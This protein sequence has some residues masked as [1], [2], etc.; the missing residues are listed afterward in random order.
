VQPRRLSDKAVARI[1]KRRA[2]A[3]GLDPDR[4]AGHSLR[5]GVASSAAAGGASERAI[6]NQTGHRSTEM[7]RRYIREANLFAADNAASLAGLYT[8]R[9]QILAAGGE[10]SVHYAP[11]DLNPMDSFAN[12]FAGV[13]GGPWTGGYQQRMSNKSH[14]AGDDHSI[15][16]DGV[17]S[18]PPRSPEFIPR[19]AARAE[20][21][22]ALMTSHGRVVLHGLGGSGKTWLAIDIAHDLRLGREID[23]IVWATARDHPL[24][25]EGL[26]RQI[27]RSLSSREV[28]TASLEGLPTAVWDLLG[29]CPALIVVDNFETI[30]PCH[31]ANVLNLLSAIP[32]NSRVLVTTRHTDF[33]TGLD[34]QSNDWRTVHLGGMSAEETRALFEAEVVRV[35]ATHLLSPSKELIEQVLD[36]TGGLPVAVRPVVEQSRRLPIGEVL[37]EIARSP[38]GP[39]PAVV[40]R[41]YAMLKPDSLAL[42]RAASILDGPA[43]LTAIAA[44]A[45]LGNCNAHLALEELNAFGLIEHRGTSVLPGGLLGLHPLVREYVRTELGAVTALEEGL[46]RKA[47][48]HYIEFV[49]ANGR[50]HDAAGLQNVVAELDVVFGLITHA[51]R[52][53]SWSEVINLVTPLSNLFWMRG[54][55]RERVHFGLMALEAARQ[56]KAIRWQGVILSRDLGWSYLRLGD[57]NDAYSCLLDA[58]PLLEQAGDFVELASAYRYLGQLDRVRGQLDACRARLDAALRAAQ[59]VEM[60]A[61]RYQV[62]R[63]R[64]DLGYLALERGELAEAREAF[65]LAEA[66]FEAAGDNFRRAIALNGLGDVAERN[67]DFEVALRSYEQSLEIARSFQSVADQGRA[68]LRLARLKLGRDPVSARAH[69][70]DARALFH[71]VP[72]GMAAQAAQAGEIISLL[73]AEPPTIQV[74]REKQPGLDSRSRGA[75]AAPRGR[76]PALLE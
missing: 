48:N 18:F 3:V 59:R 10:L 21:V 75:F 43:P 26:L 28:A 42:L 13:G 41:S 60:R 11:S 56:I 68:L 38:N 2:K 4:Y 23:A 54:F 70:L 51:Y 57:L 67:G 22:D 76:P 53:Q 14:M 52:Q 19:L 50:H 39:G 69:A 15:S 55:W 46:Y 29:E 35:E 6:M 27:A 37:D 71:Q 25:P 30:A 16:G 44:I 24:T 47:T 8:F 58:I 72:A 17:G 36:K 61:R 64:L 9:R 66:F 63:V 32:G 40:A 20:V 33:L 5:A 49:R 62:A 34:V 74:N 73:E 7:V 31:Q 45:G 12:A 1:V 65:Q